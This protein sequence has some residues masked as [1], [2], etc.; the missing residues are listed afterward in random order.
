[1]AAVPL[2]APNMEPGDWSRIR[3]VSI[4]RMP[5]PLP[6]SANPQTARKTYRLLVEADVPERPRLFFVS[7]S[8][9]TAAMQFG[10]NH[11]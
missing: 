4:C 11:R 9:E 2:E 5:E 1:M 6:V 10:A 7:M 3:A 8:E